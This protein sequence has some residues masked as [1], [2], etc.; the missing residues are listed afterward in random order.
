MTRSQDGRIQNGGNNF[1]VSNH[2]IIRYF[3]ISNLFLAAAGYTL[4]YFSKSDIF[5]AVRV[6]RRA[7]YHPENTVHQVSD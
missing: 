5:V 3:Y 2:R 4:I 1:V 6:I 7:G